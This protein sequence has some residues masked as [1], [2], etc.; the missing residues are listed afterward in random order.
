[1]QTMERTEQYR[2]CLVLPGGGFRFGYYLGVYAAAEDSGR[3]P[4]MLLASCGGAIA[5]AVIAGLPDTQARLD[6][7]TSTDMYRFLCAIQPTDRATPLQVLGDAVMRWLDHAMASRI[8]D[9]FHGYLFDLPT[10]PPLPAVLPARG[11]AIAIVGARLL[12]CPCEAGMRR[13]DRQLFAQVVFCP[14][15]AAALLRGTAAPAADPRWS[16]GAIAPFLELDCDMPVAEAVRI[17]VADM[18]YFRNYARA[19]QYYTGGVIDLFPVELAHRLAHEVIMERKLPFNPWLALPALRSV[20][21]IDGAARLRHV[22]A[23]HAHIWVDTR[24]VRRAL[25]DHCIGKKIDWRRNRISLVV[26]DTH[27]AYAAQV[28]VQWEYGYR[29][30]MAAFAGEQS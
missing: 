19:A 8:T 6:W 30:G 29:K 1:M 15:R 13:G 11:P 20:L 10:A 12:Y 28:R 25:R 7:L 22:H 18:V 9:S 5:A 27:A 14:R 3:Q 16:G 17:S 2:R 21:G 23:E 26:P 4:D 24:D